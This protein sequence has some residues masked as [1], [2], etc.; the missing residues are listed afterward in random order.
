MSQKHIRTLAKD[1]GSHLKA[2]SHA[3]THF[4]SEIIQKVLQSNSP[5]KKQVLKD[6]SSKDKDI[7]S[8]IKSFNN[9]MLK[10]C[11]G[12][13]EKEALHVLLQ[14]CTHDLKDDTSLSDQTPDYIYS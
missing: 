13:Q 5:L 4:D 2:A 7:F 8:S 1:V 12:T 11:K 6:L 3:D 10:S 14:A 9:N